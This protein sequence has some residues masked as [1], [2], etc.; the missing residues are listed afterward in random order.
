[1][2]SPSLYLKREQVLSSMTRDRPR[3]RGR[4]PSVE[5]IKLVP[6][7]LFIVSPQLE[8]APLSFS[9]PTSQK[10]EL[11]LQS[12]SPNAKKVQV[13]QKQ[14]L[15]NFYPVSVY[16]DILGASSPTFRT[17]SP[18]APIKSRVSSFASV[19]GNISINNTSYTNAA[20]YP[21]V[22]AYSEP[23]KT[24]TTS[25]GLKTSNAIETYTAKEMKDQFSYLNE[26]IVYNHALIFPDIMALPDFQSST[27]PIIIKPYVS[28]YKR[29]DNLAGDIRN[30]KKRADLYPDMLG[31]ID[32]RS[33]DPNMEDCVLI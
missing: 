8:R 15:A 17:R 16:P 4:R 21:D 32:I 9:S 31:S 23:T 24:T 1:M 20:C 18:P 29:G 5:H 2:K 7:S 13:H 12:L 22:L 6:G 10:T 19:R 11:V 3:P 30:V 26:N 14:N 28:H 33:E 27:T 25:A